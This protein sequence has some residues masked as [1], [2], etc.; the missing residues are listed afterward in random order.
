LLTMIIAVVLNKNHVE[1]VLEVLF[2]KDVIWAWAVSGI[3]QKPALQPP[4]I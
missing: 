4:N 2:V 3:T 1:N